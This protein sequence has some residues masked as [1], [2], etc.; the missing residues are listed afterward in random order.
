M[1]AAAPPEV[2]SFTAFPVQER[3]METLCDGESRIIG[4]GGG[5]RGTKT[6]GSLAALIA[7]CRVFPGSRWCVVRKD[8]QRLK[9]TVFPSFEKLRARAGEFISPIKDAQD[10]PMA[11]RCAN[12][13]AIIFRGENLDKDPQLLRF[14]GYEVN[15]F[16][17]EEADELSERTLVKEIERAGT[18]I[19]PGDQPQPPQYILNTFN[20]C[21]AWPRRRFYTP[22]RDKTIRAPYAFIPA[23]QAD[24]PAITDAQRAAWREMPAHE[25]RR[26]V[27]GDW[28]ALTGAY[29][30]TLTTD[31]LIDRK[32]LP[33][34]LPDYW[35]FWG[36]FDWG[37]AHWSVLGAWATDTDGTDILLDT[38]WVRRLQDRDIAQAA[39]DTLDARCLTRVYA[40]HDCWA[41][42][43]AR[44]APGISTADEFA[45]KGVILYRAHID[46]VNGG[47]A[48]NGQLKR[49]QVRM[50][51]TPGNLRVFDQLQTILPDEHDIRRPMKVDAD[52]N[53]EGG[54]DGADMFRY[55]IATRVE[56]GKHPKSIPGKP[57]NVA[58]PLRIEDGKLVKPEPP[59]KTLEEWVE[60]LAAKRTGRLAHRE[61]MKPQRSRR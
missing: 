58:Q 54:D 11:A 47:R 14:H 43:T 30:D 26:F 36:S 56:S 38:L 22:W 55:G 37:Y 44:G 17:N 34:K 59:P 45:A 25:Y 1:G 53:G 19:I 4:F 5:I 9:D 3:L 33:A 28:E 15:G 41:A 21:S 49:Q 40:G 18:W 42:P 16:L 8:L 50:V 48:V 61:R 12:G 23:T 13:S 51:R 7:L 35:R 52:A 27:E 31:C 20:P 6:W 60:R 32:D 46:P 10:L 29:Y 39:R 24:N 2:V 57:A